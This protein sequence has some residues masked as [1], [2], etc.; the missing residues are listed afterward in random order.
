MTPTRP[1]RFLAQVERLEDRLTPS[2]LPLHSAEPLLLRD[3][4]TIQ[5]G[6]TEAAAVRFRS[7]GNTGGAE[8]FLGIPDLGQGGNRVER[9]Y[10]WSRPGTHYVAFAYDAETYQLAAAAYSFETKAYV[11]LAFERFTEPLELDSILIRLADRDVDSQVDFLGVE[12]D[13]TPLG[14]FY[15]DDG[16]QEF[17]F[18]SKDLTDGFFLTGYIVLDG[19]FSF[20]QELSKV[21]ILVGLGLGLGGN[22]PAPGNSGCDAGIV[23]ALV[24]CSESGHTPFSLRLRAFA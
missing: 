11:D 3:G 20:S 14:D 22:G 18:P 7:F 15:G 8:L 17:G 24:M 13:G 5:A 19:A 10:I 1:S 4:G 6:P 12:V 16:A 2:N 23:S 9:D 21:E